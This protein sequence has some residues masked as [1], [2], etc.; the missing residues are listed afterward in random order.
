MALNA[1]T[2]PNPLDPAQRAACLQIRFGGVL[3][4]AALTKIDGVKTT[5]TWKEQKSK[6]TSGSVN[7]FSGTK[8][9]HPKMTFV[10]TT[11]AEWVWIAMLWNLL[12]PVPGLGQVS[13]TMPTPGT[14]PQQVSAIGSAPA[15]A[16]PTAQSLL[17][18]AQTAYA[19]VGAAA[20]PSSDTTGSSSSGSTTPDPGPRPPT[21]SVQ[22]WALAFHGITAVAREEWDGP[23][24][25]D[26]NGVEV[27][28]TFIADKPPVPAGAGA[29]APPP[30]TPPGQQYQANP[31]PGAGGSAAGASPTSTASAGAAGT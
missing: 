26:T 14:A 11:P 27:H 13:T 21:I 1:L 15:A 29:M 18:A 28:I 4:L 7:S 24:F 17:D 3:A 22:Y 30:T 5:D 8:Y 20:A 19:N 9:G 2:V 16:A 6:E 10:A 23:Y 12:A 31:L 25:T